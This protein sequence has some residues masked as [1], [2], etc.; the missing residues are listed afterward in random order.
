MIQTDIFTINGDFGKTVLV[1]V[2]FTT[3]MGNKKE[4]AF[5]LVEI[6]KGSC[7]FLLGNLIIVYRVCAWSR[8]EK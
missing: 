5:F 3:V 7:I 4:N 2:E 8:N 6:L 1:R